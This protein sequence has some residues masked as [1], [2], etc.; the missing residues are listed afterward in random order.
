[1]M[2]LDKELDVEIGMGIS[3]VGEETGR[4]TVAA[5]GMRPVWFHEFFTLEEL[6]SFIAELVKVGHPNTKRADEMRK[7]FAGLLGAPP[8]QS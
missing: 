1:M 7:E 5:R 8:T 6:D 3:S 2:D 4:P